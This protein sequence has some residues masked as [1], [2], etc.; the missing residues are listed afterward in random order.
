MYTEQVMDNILINK[1]SKKP[2]GVVA[3]V[4]GSIP[5]FSIKPLPAQ[6]WF[7]PMEKPQKV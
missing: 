3:G 1:K 2:R 6:Y 5:G 7:L 4:A